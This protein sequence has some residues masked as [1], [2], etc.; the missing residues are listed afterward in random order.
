VDGPVVIVTDRGRPNH[1]LLTYDAYLAMT[2]ADA[3]L[4]RVF[5]ELPDTVD[6]AVDFPR[7]DEMPRSAVFD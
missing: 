6:L 7:S 1:V 3:S 5:A 4:G 2:G